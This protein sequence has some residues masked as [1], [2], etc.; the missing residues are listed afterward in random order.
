[1]NIQPRNFG[2]TMLIAL[3]ATGCTSKLVLS[4]KVAS[5]L[6]LPTAVSYVE[7][8]AQDKHSKGVPCNATLGLRHLSLPGET[9]LFVNVE[10]ETFAK[11]GLVVKYSERGIVSEVAFNT[12]PSSDGIE[13]AT[14]AATSLLPFLGLLPAVR[15]PAPA[16]APAN[17][18]LREDAADTRVACDAGEVPLR[19]IPLATY[20]D[21][22]QLRTIV[23]EL[24]DYIKTL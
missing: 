2:I 5:G 7:F 11:T 17:L 22:V 18:E 8:Y 9:K 13:A 14:G 1:M 20:L 19:L 16:V 24:R 4:D 6:P 10:P 15:A 21:A 3:S 12:E 23:A